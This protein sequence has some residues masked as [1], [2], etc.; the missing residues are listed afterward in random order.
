MI[1]YTNA[2]LNDLI[3][4][5]TG[6]KSENIQYVISKT[7]VEN[8]SNEISFTLN[9]LFLSPFR[10]AEFYCFYHESEI[11]LNEIFNYCKQLFKNENLFYE[12]SIKIL[13]HLFNSSKHPQIKIGEFYLVLFDNLLLGTEPVKAIGIFKSENKEKIFKL[14]K[15]KDYFDLDLIEG[16]STSKID[17]GCLI[18]NTDGENGFKVCVM[19]NTNKGSDAQYWKEDF[20]KLKPCN[21]E[22]N[23]TKNFLSLTKSYITQQ[24][25]EEFEV[26]KADQIDLLN[27]SV[28]YFKTHDNF[29]K[30]EFETEVFQDTG[31]IKSFR[32]FDDIYQTDNELE[33]SSQFEIS[34]QAVKKQAKIFKSIL[35]LDKNFAIYIHGNRQLIEQGVEKD[36]RKF[37]KIY[38][39]EES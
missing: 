17:K 36:G 24:L 6:N 27:R 30:K 25:P 18:F 31:I 4:H 9:N 39:N 34:P 15:S 5:Q 20:L 38:F 21:D 29:D 33:L 8:I 1:N 12:V 28:E 19:D 16:I 35:K 2:S 10:N 22:F 23:N 11:E 32:K 26:A 3:I 14:R 13:K 37:Y 7:K